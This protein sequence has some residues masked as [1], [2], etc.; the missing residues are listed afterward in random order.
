MKAESQKAC[1]NGAKLRLCDLVDG[2]YNENSR[3]KYYRL[4]LENGEFVGIYQKKQNNL[5]VEKMFYENI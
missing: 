3:H 4:Y 5:V 1:L 2:S